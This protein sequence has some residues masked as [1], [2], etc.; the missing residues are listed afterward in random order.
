MKLHLQLLILPLLFTSALCAQSPTEESLALQRSLIEANK[1]FL[2]EDY[3][4]ARKSYGEV[5]DKDDDN[6]TAYFGVSRIYLREKDM[7]NAEKYAKLALLHDDQ[8]TWFYEHLIKIKKLQRD[9]E[10]L[11][12]LYQELLAIDDREQYRFELADAY[13]RTKNYKKA[14][15]VLED[16]E[17]DEVDPAISYR[18]ARTFSKLNKP[19]KALKEYERLI[20]SDP[21]ETRYLHLL[22]N[23]H[24]ATDH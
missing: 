17:G 7:A 8:N 15:K 6:S 16:M 2:L 11:I 20:A 19:K 24:R 21:R 23:H 18:K 13:E 9:F 10:G 3:A 12:P 14:L 22:A 4:Q 5:L 1:F